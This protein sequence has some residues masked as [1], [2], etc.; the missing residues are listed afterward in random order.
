[1]MFLQREAKSRIPKYSQIPYFLYTGYGDNSLSWRL[2]IVRILRHYIPILLVEFSPSNGYSVGDWGFV[3]HP[4]KLS[5][6]SEDSWSHI[7]YLWTTAC[8]TLFIICPS[9]NQHSSAMILY[10]LLLGMPQCWWWACQVG[11]KGSNSKRLPAPYQTL[12]FSASAPCDIN[13]KS[14][15]NVIIVC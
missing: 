11:R 9:Y 15:I 10:T 12:N 8:P 2:R 7:I 4:V 5:V 6:A 1:M 3:A 13:V 14:S